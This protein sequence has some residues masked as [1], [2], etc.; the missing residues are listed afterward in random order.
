M[1]KLMGS[2][3]FFGRYP[4]FK[5]HDIDKFEIVDT[6][7]FKEVRIIR[8]MG[9]DLFQFRRQDT[10]QAYIDIALRSDLPMVVGK[11]LIPEF[12][13]EIGFTIEDLPKIKPLIDK[14]DDKHK[15][16]EIIYNAYLENGDFVLTQIQRD[17]AYENYK[18]TRN[19]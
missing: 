1:F 7:E 11:F 5:S 2:T 9:K 15:Y 16:E 14:L 6:A 3:Y 19:L 10:T 17:Q 4:D 12:C 8:G 18:K 13:D